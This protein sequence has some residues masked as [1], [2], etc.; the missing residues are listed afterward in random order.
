M[1]KINQINGFCASKYAVLKRCN[2]LASKDELRK[3]E[4]EYNKQRIALSLKHSDSPHT[5]IGLKSQNISDE[6]F[7]NA[8]MS[9]LQKK[10][11]IL[12][13]ENEQAV[14]AMCEK[15]EKENAKTDLDEESRREIW[16]Q[17]PSKFDL[18]E[19][20]KNLNDEYQMKIE[21]LKSNFK[22][23]TTEKFQICEKE[24]SLNEKK[25]RNSGK[26]FQVVNS[27]LNLYLRERNLNST[28]SDE[29]SVSEVILQERNSLQVMCERVIEED[30]R[31]LCEEE[32]EISLILSLSPYW[33]MQ[34]DTRD[35]HNLLHQKVFDLIRQHEGES[36]LTFL[37]SFFLSPS[38]FLLLFL[39]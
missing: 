30:F 31:I 39:F 21:K 16:V 37:F 36:L 19:E 4:T 33:G 5:N 24:K 7:R 11:L 10:L 14:H 28:E 13:E 27:P 20:M 18:E 12:L 25:I 23:Y 1:V 8:Q 2:A 35:C 29:F 26:E 17:D 38:L 9:N 34:S 3:L 6:K 15:I 32:T 22:I